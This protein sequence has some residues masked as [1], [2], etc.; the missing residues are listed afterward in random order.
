MA[1]LIDWMSSAISRLNRVRRED[2]KILDAVVALGPI[3]LGPRAFVFDD[4]TPLDDRFL[5]SLLRRR[6]L[7][8]I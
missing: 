2:R 8:L 7:V 4:E 3:G 1:R 5:E 6:V